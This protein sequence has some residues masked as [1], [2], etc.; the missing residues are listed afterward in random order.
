M[1]V[2]C[3]INLQYSLAKIYYQTHATIKLNLLKLLIHTFYSE[4][5][6]RHFNEVNIQKGHPTVR[7]H[8]HLLYLPWLRRCVGTI[9]VTQMLE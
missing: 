1:L 7:P 2:Y 6:S 5:I 9:V 4:M 3:L 8:E